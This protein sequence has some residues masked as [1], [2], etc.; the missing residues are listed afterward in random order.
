VI[1]AAGG[2]ATEPQSVTLAS[3]GNVISLHLV[4]SAGAAVPDAQIGSVSVYDANSLLFLNEGNSTNGVA[5]LSTGAVGPVVAV[6]SG[7]NG[8][9]L[10]VNAYT[11]SP[12]HSATL[13]RYTV[14]GHVKPTGSAQL[15]AS[16][17]TN[18]FGTVDATL[19]TGLGAFWDARAQR[20]PSAA[21]ITDALGTWQASLFGG[22][23]SLMA[24][25]LHSLPR[26]AAVAANVSADASTQDIA[27][28]PGGVISGNLHDEAQANIASVPVSVVDSG[29]NTIGSAVSDASG[30]YSIAVPFG[31]YEVFAGGALT[32]NIGVSSS[33]PTHTLDLTRFQITGRMTDASLNPIAGTVYFGGGNV[34]ATA[35]GTYTLNAFQGL[36]WVL[37]TPP[38]SS[39]AIGFAYETNVLVNAQTVQSIR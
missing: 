6:V 10:A 31:T 37:F 14:A 34:T 39:P 18:N 13:T 24:V 32:G 21:T 1:N 36:N 35:L 15:T 26:S 12:T 8:E 25:Q 27:V 9:T 28:D 17:G 33:S 4:D 16:T 29:H 22:S 20:S 5:T 3:G 2:G 11:A 38:A 30:N 23:Y 19:Q 7:Q